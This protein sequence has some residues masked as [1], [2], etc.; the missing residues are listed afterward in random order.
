MPTSGRRILVC[1]DD[2]HIQRALEFT[3][4]RGG[5]EVIT[6]AD[7]RQALTLLL[8]SE[9]DLLITDYHMPHMNGFELCQCVRSEP[10]LKQLPVILLITD[11]DCV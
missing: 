9:F 10:Q 8:E 7:G 4:F 5:H 11:R 6:V 1:D 2:A 3:L